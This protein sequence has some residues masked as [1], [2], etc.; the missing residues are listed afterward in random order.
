VMQALSLAAILGIKRGD[1]R[2]SK[3]T[4]FVKNAA[5]PQKCLQL[6]EVKVSS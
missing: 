6:G 3:P 4:R 2:Y 5:I 1:F